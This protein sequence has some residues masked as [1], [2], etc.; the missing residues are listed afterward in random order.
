M[1]GNSL[2][3][4]ENAS[5]AMTNASMG[6]RAVTVAVR[7]T[8]SMSAISPQNPPGPIVANTVSPWRTSAV[9][10]KMM[11]NSRPV[12]PS[13]IKSLPAG[14]S[15]SSVRR[16]MRASSRFEQDENSGT[17]LIA[18]SFEVTAAEPTERDTR[19]NW[20]PESDRFES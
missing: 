9:P 4:P 8:R 16:A 20:S 2:R 11:K 7:G 15:I 13:R 19:G 5:P 12:S 3:R 17:P 14:K 1:F 6:D 18:V 10:L